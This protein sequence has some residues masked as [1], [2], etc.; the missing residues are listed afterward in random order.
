[1]IWEEQACPAGLHDHEEIGS[2][3]A[4]GADGPLPFEDVLARLLPDNAERV[5]A[6]Q[7][8]VFWYLPT[9]CPAMH[10]NFADRHDE[11]ATGPKLN[12]PGRLI[13]VKTANQRYAYQ[14]ARRP[15]CPPPVSGGRVVPVAD[16]VVR[17]D[18]GVAATIGPITSQPGLGVKPWIS[19][20]QPLHA[21]DQGSSRAARR[22]LSDHRTD[23][24]LLIVSS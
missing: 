14:A 4:C 10:P 20:C 3:S 2:S 16:F 9:T 11:G 5:R 7:H 19:A 21:L 24:L 23:T 8:S 22:R 13:K 1:V 15:H 18:M 12:G 6:L 17:S